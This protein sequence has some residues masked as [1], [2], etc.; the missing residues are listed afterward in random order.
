MCQGDVRKHPGFVA[1]NGFDFRLVVSKGCKRSSYLPRI[2]VDLNHCARF[3]FLSRAIDK[4]DS[5]SLSDVGKLVP[6]CPS[7]IWFKGGG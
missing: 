3:V 7:C 1:Q 2:K 4:I 6:T 5:D